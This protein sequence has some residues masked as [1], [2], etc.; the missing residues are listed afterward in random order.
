M[1]LVEDDLRCHVLG[2]PAECPR[3]PPDLELLG[4]SKVHQLDV[5]GPVQ[6]EILGLQVPVDDPPGVEVV[7]GLHN[8]G[9][10][11]TGGAV[12]KVSAVPEDEDFGVWNRKFSL[13]LLIRL[14]ENCPQLPSQTRLHEHVEVLPVLEGLEEPDYELAVRLLHDLLLG[15]DVLLLTS[16]HNLQDTF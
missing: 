12:V 6:E 15:H 3:L 10:V 9:R 2:G 7:E 5:A 13:F 8:A 4:E 14:P 11:E 1:S 16:L